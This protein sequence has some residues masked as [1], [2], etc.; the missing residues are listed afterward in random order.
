MGRGGAESPHLS[1]FSKAKKSGDFWHFF[2]Q[3]KVQFSILCKVL[4]PGHERS[5]HLARSNSYKMVKSKCPGP[6]YIV[7][8]FQRQSAPIAFPKL[9]RAR[10]ANVSTKNIPFYSFN[11]HLI[12]QL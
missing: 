7:H 12:L 2:W 1:S 8:F 6:D 3:W 9:S 4:I 11:L 5:G 10:N